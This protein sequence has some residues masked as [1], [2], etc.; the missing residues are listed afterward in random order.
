MTS[1]DSP[2]ADERVTYVEFALSSSEYPFV[3]V[4]EADGA[5]A[6]L[7]E[8]IP[9]GAGSYAEFFSVS[10]VD[11]ESVLAQALDHPSVEAR[12]VERFTDEALFEFVVDDGCPAVFLGESGALPCT[13]ESRGGSGTVGAE[14]PPSEDV[15]TVV[16]DFTD[17]YPDAELR[18]KREQSYGTPIF[19]QECLRAALETDMTDRQREILGAA[20]DAGYYDWPRE[21]TAEELAERFGI[22]P[23]TFH[24]HLR[25]AEQ[26]LVALS[27]RRA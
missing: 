20:H 3:A 4:S 24:Q 5:A 25:A 13:V 27:L 22:C 2:R 17:A 15:S 11:P 18:V 12:L 6:L 1:Q 21:V 16:N 23:A 7:R 26:K 19:G 8:F 14:V 9:R 10:G